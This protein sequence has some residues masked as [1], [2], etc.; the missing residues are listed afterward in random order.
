MGRLYAWLRMRP[1]ADT[2]E[3]PIWQPRSRTQKRRTKLFP[4]LYVFFVYPADCVS[5]RA[6]KGSAGAVYSPSKL[7]SSS[8]SGSTRRART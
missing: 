7:K 1:Y 6:L 5:V 3:R 8:L 2:G 4:I